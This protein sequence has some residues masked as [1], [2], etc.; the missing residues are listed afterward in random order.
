MPLV[1]TRNTPLPCIA[2]IDVFINP[3]YPTEYG[4]AQMVKWSKSLPLTARCLSPLPGFDSQPVHVR[5]F[6]VTL[7][8]YVVGPQ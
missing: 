5:K 2:T 6:P 3:I 4:L 1:H 7:G 8:L